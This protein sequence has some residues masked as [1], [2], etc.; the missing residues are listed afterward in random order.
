MQSMLI[1]PSCMSLLS[2]RL[3]LVYNLCVAPSSSSR[4]QDLTPPE[5]PAGLDTLVAAAQQWEQEAT[6]DGSPTWIVYLLEHR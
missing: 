2:C 3:C 4:P 1:T 5:L 6:D